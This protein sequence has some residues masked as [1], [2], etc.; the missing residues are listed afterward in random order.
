[1]SA[2]RFF[3]TDLALYDEYGV[4]VLFVNH[5][6]FHQVLQ[7]LQEDGEEGLNAI[8]LLRMLGQVKTDVT[9]SKN[10]FSLS[11]EK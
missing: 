10:T 5:K 8:S 3:F 1:M 6:T 7:L 2:G 11:K 9:D 4:S